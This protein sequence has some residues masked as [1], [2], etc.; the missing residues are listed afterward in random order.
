MKKKRSKK[1]FLHSRE[2]KFILSTLPYD[3]AAQWLSNPLFRILETLGAV[4]E[5][6]EEVQPCSHQPL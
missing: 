6:E 5:A 2:P 3:S 4:R 1:N